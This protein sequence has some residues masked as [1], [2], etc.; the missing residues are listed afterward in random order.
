MNTTKTSRQLSAKAPQSA[1]NAQISRPLN[2]SPASI[3]FGSRVSVVTYIRASTP[4]AAARQVRLCDAFIDLKAKD[5]WRK[6]HEFSERIVPGVPVSHCGL[7][8]LMKALTSGSIKIV[9]CACTDMMV[10]FPEEQEQLRG[11]LHKHQCQ[12]L[13]APGSTIRS[14]RAREAA[15]RA[16][17]RK[18]LRV[19]NKPL[20]PTNPV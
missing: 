14:L 16:K 1:L 9:V 8:D 15:A 17:M 10:L 3:P 13:A 11:F 6:V 5:G 19:M 2:I 12:M 18:A 20:K 7:H 4:E